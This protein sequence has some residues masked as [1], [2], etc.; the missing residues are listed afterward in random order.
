MRLRIG[1]ERGGRPRPPEPMPDQRGDTSASEGEPCDLDTNRSAVGL[2]SE[3]KVFVRRSHDAPD[4]HAN[5]ADHARHVL[6]AGLFE[7]DQ[8]GPERAVLQALDDRNRHP[9]PS[10][11]VIADAEPLMGQV[12]ATVDHELRSEK[13]ANR[14]A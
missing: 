7:A 3:E 1:E 9:F 4:D 11:T 14:P 2:L 13:T 8:D 10:L 5:R 6:E 12:S